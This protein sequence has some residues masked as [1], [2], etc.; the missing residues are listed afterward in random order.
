MMIDASLTTLILA[1]SPIRM[2]YF[3]LLHKSF[4]EDNTVQKRLPLKR[5]TTPAK[6][7]LRVPN[8]FGRSVL[9]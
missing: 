5:R 2:K 4:T 8:Y 6:L 9:L 1:I 7:C 3:Y